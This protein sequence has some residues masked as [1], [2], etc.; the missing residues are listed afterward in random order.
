MKPVYMLDVVRDG[1]RWSGTVAEHHVHTHGRTL[2]EV[3]SAARDA[4]ALVLDV[5]PAE[6]AV[7]LRGE[8]PLLEA[9]DHARTARARAQERERAALADVARELAAHRVSRADIA[10]LTRTTPGAV[11]RAI[12]PRPDGGGDTLS[13]NV[14]PARGDDPI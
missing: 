5:P 13:G 9:H 14:L 8:S 3:E 2:A 6:V 11:I 4:L 10:R 12:R 1:T 7:E